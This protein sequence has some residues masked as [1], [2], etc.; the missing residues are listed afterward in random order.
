MAGEVVDIPAIIF[1]ANISWILYKATN[2]ACNAV[3]FF[4]LQDLIVPGRICR[5]LTP[6]Q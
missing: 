4:I 1:E 5:A 3:K 6:A 2:S